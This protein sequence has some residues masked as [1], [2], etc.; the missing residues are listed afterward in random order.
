MFRV[1]HTALVW[2]IKRLD[3]EFWPAIPYTEAIKYSTTKKI[4]TQFFS[5]ENNFSL[6]KLEQ[7]R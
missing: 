2:F 3:I 5:A 6:S 4:T 7:I 1:I